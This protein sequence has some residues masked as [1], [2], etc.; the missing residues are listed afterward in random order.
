MRALKIPRLVEW[1]GSD[2]RIPE[3]EFADNPYFKRVYEDAYEYKAIESYANS[4]ARQIRFA[5]AGFASVA[6]VGMLQ[7][8]QQ[9]IFPQT[10]VVPQR[11]LLE[12]YA[13]A[14]PD[15][16]KAKPLIVHSP[17]APVPKA[18][19]TF[20]VRSRVCAASTI[21]TSG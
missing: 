19:R 6:P 15:P 17:T 21:S 7:Y 20:S 2:I 16:Q 5:E 1:Q 11:L 12:D 10:Y 18:R 9:D 13:V 8:V 14:Y 3:V 4:R